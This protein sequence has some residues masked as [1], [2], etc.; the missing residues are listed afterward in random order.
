M[1]KFVAFFALA[2]VLAVCAPAQSAEG[3]PPWAYRVNAVEFL[4]RADDGSLRR[5]PDSTAGFTLSQL[6]DFFF[7]PDWHPDDHPRMPEI[8]ARGRKP[9]VYACGFCHR[10]DGPGG[11]ENS[12]LAGLPEA[13]IVQQVA[14]FKSGARKSSVPQ[15][16]PVALMTSLSKAATEAEVASASAHFSSLKPRKTITVIETNVVPKTY[17]AGWFLAAAN[18]RDKERIGH[19]IIEVPK[20]LDRFESRDTRAEFIAYVP[21]GSIAKGESLVTTGGNGKTTQCGTCHGHDLRG[22][23][24]IPGIAGRSPSYVVRQLYDIQHGKRT[25]PGSA[26]MAGIVAKLN[27]DDFVSL[28][29]YAASL[30]P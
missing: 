25:G 26:A 11:P 20:D 16:A 9:E 4:R 13:Y 22:L 24:P 19:R 10:A 3:P 18:H 5:V 15:R 12:S 14:D 8:V 2:L 27:E 7:P 29:A 28:A 1:E 23:G 6:Q 21:M 17:V 30:M